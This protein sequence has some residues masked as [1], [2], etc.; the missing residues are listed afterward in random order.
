MIDN[1]AYMGHD[2]NTVSKNTRRQVKGNF[3]KTL[4]DHVSID[5]FEGKKIRTIPYFMGKSMVS[6]IFSRKQTS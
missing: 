6:C 2:K 3:R 1:M 4:A 5:W